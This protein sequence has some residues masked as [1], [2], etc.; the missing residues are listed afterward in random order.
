MSNFENKLNQNNAP[1][2]GKIIDES[3]ATFKKTVWISGAGILLLLLIIM[4]ITFFAIFKYMDI[5]STEEFIKK[6]QTLDKDFN[7][8]M[9]NAAI[10][11]IL[12]P[13]IAPI[14]AGFYKL[15]H[16]AK[17]NKEFGLNNLFDYYKNPYFM[18]LAVSAF[19]ATIYSNVVGLLLVYLNLPLIGSIM[20]IFIAL[21]FIFAI[22]LII[23]DKQP[24][25]QA[26]AN[27]SK[28]FV[29]HPFTIIISLVFAFI[30]ALL[31][32]FAL[33]IGILFT[34]GYFY[35]MN[36]TLYNEIYPI[37]NKNTI[38]EIGQE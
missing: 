33:C 32:F 25:L 38:D 15:N 23:F 11:I 36:Y 17:Q 3:F 18:S 37:E 8:L 4:P 9:M 6:S 30:I 34:V 7:Y 20:Q 1:D 27:S 22:P 10:G 5:S 13:F 24:A 31:G 2:I 28:I 35:T 29:K 19:L 21:L 14:T 16:L 26:M 12:A